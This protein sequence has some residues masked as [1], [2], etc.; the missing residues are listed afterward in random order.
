MF[1]AE[2]IFTMDKDHQMYLKAG[3]HTKCEANFMAANHEEQS[4]L[5]NSFISFIH[6]AQNDL[7]N[8]EVYV[9]P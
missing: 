9:I 7:N 4:E 6:Q 2:D 3:Y 5:T 1:L 8:S